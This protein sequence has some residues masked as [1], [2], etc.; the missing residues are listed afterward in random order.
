MH[1]L[2]ILFQ[3][4]SFA[5][6]RC[7]ATLQGHRGGVTCVR[8][9]MHERRIFSGALDGDLRFWDIDTGKVWRRE[10][11]AEDLE[12]VLTSERR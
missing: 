2:C 7:L 6:G 1:R 10:W 11:N 5:E 8:F 3:I 12:T 9:N 4:W